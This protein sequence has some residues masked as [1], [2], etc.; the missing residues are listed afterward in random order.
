[1]CIVAVIDTRNPVVEACCNVGSEGYQGNAPGSN[2]APV[3]RTLEVDGQ[4]VTLRLEPPVWDA[5]EDLSHR[6]GRGVGAVV[7]EMAR[8]GGDPDLESAIR[9]HLTR[10]FKEAV[11][12]E[13]P[14][15][16]F[17]ESGDT[18]SVA[19]GPLAAALDALGPLRE[20]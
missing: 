2:L 15:R 19:R 9:T 1:M 6:E 11:E 17:S 16:G 7:A 8:Q 12:P 18:D 20:P 5:L 14:R 13:R 3:A 10:Y 4:A